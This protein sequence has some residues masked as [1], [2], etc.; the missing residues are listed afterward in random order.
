MFNSAHILEKNDDPAVASFW[1]KQVSKTVFGKVHWTDHN[2]VLPNQF[3]KNGTE[4]HPE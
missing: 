4:F 3:K 2:I 1:S